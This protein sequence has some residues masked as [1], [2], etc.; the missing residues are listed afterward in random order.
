MARSKKDIPS[1]DKPKCK[2]LFD[3]IKHIQSQQDPK[4]FD[5]LSDAD[6]KT[7]SNW[8]INRFMSMIPEYTPV[9]NE[10]QHLSSI[11]E[12]EHYYKLLIGII[13]KRNVF[14]DYI[15]AKPKKY[16][17]SIILF[18]AKHYECSSREILDYLDIITEESIKN[19]YYMNGYDEKE[20][21][22]IFK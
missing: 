4:Y 21:E 18:V 9:I 20:V 12:P 14:A 2:G 22:K 6:K 16:N 8:M 3:H 10:I 13:P 11:L 1:E 19:I 7:W 5:T 17:D 15:K